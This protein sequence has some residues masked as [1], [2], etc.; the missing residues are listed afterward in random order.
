MFAVTSCENS[1]P[2]IYG[3][4]LRGAPFRQNYEYEVKAKPLLLGF[5]YE[6]L[7]ASG[8]AYGEGRF[9]LTKQG[10]VENLPH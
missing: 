9:R 3:M 6:V 5:T 10:V 7:A 8:S 1:F 2:V 4:K